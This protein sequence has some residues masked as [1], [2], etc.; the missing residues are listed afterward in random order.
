MVDPDSSSPTE[1]I[2]IENLDIALAHWHINSWG[3][4]EYVITKMAEII[5]ETTVYTVGEPDPESENP[6]GAIEFHNVVDDLP[7]STAKLRSRLGRPAE[8]SIWE[9]V[10]WQSYGSPDVLIT[11]GS[12]PRAVITPGNTIHINYCHSP[13]RWFYDLY[14]DRKD[15]FFGRLARPAIRYLRTRDS[16]IDNRVDH[17]LANS[18]IIAR[19][20][21]KYYKRGAEVVYPPVEINRYENRGD[22]GFYFHLGRLDSEKGIEAVIK[23]F[24][25]LNEQIIFAGG[26]GDA[27][28]IGQIRAADNM[29]YVGFISEDAKYD[30]LG[31]CRAVVFNGRNEDFGI[32]PIEANASGKPCLARND[33]FPGLFVEA[34]ENGL[35]HGGSAAS[36]RAAVDR[37][38]AKGVAADPA[39]FVNRFSMSAFETQLSE[40]ITTAYNSFQ[41]RFTVE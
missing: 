33:G 26:E 18:P 36:I 11:S 39:S 15:S 4:A 24:D 14:H 22:E 25:E 40:S 31:R 12:T 21:W 1:E 35:L 32:V 9:D 2:S 13:P 29:E 19:R 5:D 20:L 10:D 8:Y 27:D 16:A 38:E 30:L 34:G 3:G 28:M 23:A 37:L 17:Y 7:E 6:Y 41:T